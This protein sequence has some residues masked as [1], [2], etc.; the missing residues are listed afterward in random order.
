MLPELLGAEG[1]VM[2]SRRAPTVTAAPSAPPPQRAFVENGSLLGAI[3][4]T[5]APAAFNRVAFDRGLAN[6]LGAPVALACSFLFASSDVGGFF[7]G[8][9]AMPFHELGHA[10]ASWLG[11]R[12]AVPLP[13]FTIWLEA[14]SFAFGLCLSVALAAAGA[15]AWRERSRFGM[16]LAGVTLAAQLVVSVLLPRSQSAMLQLLGGALGEIVLGGLCLIGFHFPLPDR[17]RW[18]FWRWPCLAP[19]SLCFVHALSLWS[20]AARDSAALPWGSALGSDADGD[21]NRLVRDF[22]WSA[23][24]LARFYANVSGLMTLAVVGTLAYAAWRH[25][26]ST[27]ALAERRDQRDLAR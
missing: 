22:D 18:D 2:P 13:F 4:A 7:A 9:V 11:S 20:R 25:R 6:V 17:L 19:A 21:M 27:L 10:L 16:A 12:F 3:R 14:P 15:Y 8:L 24:E 5:P 1:V 26:R 23:Q